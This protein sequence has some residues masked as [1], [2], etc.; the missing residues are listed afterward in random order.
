MSSIC[1]EVINICFCGEVSSEKRDSSTDT[2]CTN[3]GSGEDY[4]M[5]IVLETQ[6][7]HTNN[8][9]DWQNDNNSSAFYPEET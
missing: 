5:I 2:I 4:D 3:K 7:C 8:A 6:N 1:D 9:N